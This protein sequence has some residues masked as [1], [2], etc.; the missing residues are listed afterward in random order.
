M[1]P[2]IREYIARLDIDALL[3]KLAQSVSDIPEETIFLV[4]LS[5]LL[6]KEGINA[7]LTLYDIASLVARMDEDEPSKLEQAIHMAEDNAF[8]SIQMKSGRLN[9]NEGVIRNDKRVGDFAS[10]PPIS[11]KQSIS[12]PLRRVSETREFS[13]G[14]SHGERERSSSSESDGSDG[15]ALQRNFSVFSP[16]ECKSSHSPISVARDLS[17]EGEL[18][19]QSSSDSLTDGLTSTD[20]TL[21]NGGEPPLLPQRISRTADKDGKFARVASF[22]GF[23][24]A[25][26]Y[27]VGKQSSIHQVSTSLQRERRRLI[28]KTNEFKQL[29]WTLASDAVRAMISRIKKSTT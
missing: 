23:D 24:S 5:H 25:A 10:V 7:G 4:R 19:R 14:S 18:T 3:D 17:D 11:K 21:S 27:D 15:A 9:M 20:G 22:A 13:N 28:S 29:R 8:S 6:I 2:E 16:S 26:I 12:I 1:V